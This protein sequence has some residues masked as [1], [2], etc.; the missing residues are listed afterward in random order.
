MT[1]TVSKGSRA[2]LLVVLAYLTITG[3]AGTSLRPEAAK[4]PEVAPGYLMPYLPPKDH[5]NSL[6]LLPPPP[7]DGSAAFAA[8]RA[9][10]QEA[11][12]LRNTPRW[13]LAIDDADL[14]FPHAAGT[15]SC[16]VGAPITEKDTPRLYTLLWR[17]KSDAVAST[18]SA[19]DHYM[20]IRPFVAEKITSCTPEEEKRLS[21]NGSYPSGH[22]AVGWTW[23]L[24]L[25]EL[26]LDRV[27]AILE[28]GRAFGESRIVCGMHWQSDIDA[29]R[30]VGAGVV[31]R[32]HA[33][34]AFRADLEAAGAELNAVRAGGLQ[35]D[36]DCRAEREALSIKS[37]R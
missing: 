35:P 27:D 15:F 22:A 6:A 21:G 20:R 2:V 29:G 30:I 24:I 8:D 11:L 16:A 1:K 34:P 19:K 31:A 12:K 36:R 5:P 10:A 26:A 4:I 14:K 7:A 32:L 17:V 23:A 3:C 18:F 9:I 33:D 37:L 13:G 28:R 25:A